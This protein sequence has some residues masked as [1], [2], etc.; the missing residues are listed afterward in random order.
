MALHSPVKR[1]RGYTGLSNKGQMLASDL[2]FIALLTNARYIS[3]FVCSAFFI[4]ELVAIFLDALS[5]ATGI[6]APEFST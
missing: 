1:V 4:L 2:A 5:T 6:P 3:R